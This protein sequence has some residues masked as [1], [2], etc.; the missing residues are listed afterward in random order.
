M[1]SA[2]ESDEAVS[3]IVGTLL[4]ILITVTAAA[5]LAIMVSEFQKEEMERQSHLQDVENE[6]LRIM[7]LALIY[8]G[9]AWNESI[10]ST[11]PGNWSSLDLDILNMNVED[12]RITAV[13]INGWYA[14]SF[15]CE[16]IEY[17]IS[18]RLIV[19]A[20]RQRTL[21]LNFTDGFS[22]PYNVTE[23]EAVRVRVMTSFYNTFERT[24][25]PPSPV[26]RFSVEQEDLVVAS[27]GVIVL[28]G[29]DSFDD[30]CVAAWNWTVEDGSAT[31]PAPG[32]WSDSGNV[33]AT[34]LTGRIARVIPASA[35]PFR[36]TLT[37]T[38]ETRMVGSSS[39]VVVP[40]NPGYNPPTNLGVTRP[41]ADRIDATVRD[42]AGSPVAGAPVTFVVTHNP[43]GNLTLDHWS[44][45]TGSDGSL[46]TNRTDGAGI[47]RVTSGTL[48]PVDVAF[49]L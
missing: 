46:L 10:N 23:S 31:F 9:A 25:Q 26:L 17:G 13:S 11:N 27:R 16:G 44:G 28:D 14:S 45:L 41:T 29:S 5:G 30:G 33:T 2:Y 38:D 21:T 49:A 4:L 8:D 39:P 20:T 1:S 48:P 18:H 37:V 22:S 36:V 6:E 40:A 24:F 32:T 15:S 3:V 43:Y 19:P 12:S 42:A 35:G 34:S 7:G 47:V